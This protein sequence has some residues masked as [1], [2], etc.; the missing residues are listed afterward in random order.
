[1]SNTDLYERVRKVP[2]NAKKQISAGRLKGMTDINP[3]WRIKTLTEEFG[4]CGIGWKLEIVRSWLDNGSNNEVTANVEIRLYVKVNEQWSDA[5]P[6]I[7]GSKFVSKETGGMYTDDDAYK[8]AYTDALS[9]ACKALGIGADVYYEKDTTKYST[10]QQ[11]DSGKQGDAAGKHQLQGSTQQ[12]G[13][14]R[15]K[16]KFVQVNDLIKDTDISM[17]MVNEFISNN[18]GKSI[19]NNNLTDE[20]FKKL[21]FTLRKNL[22]IE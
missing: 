15:P 12:Q 10:P 7:G 2:D 8:K 13:G 4:V 3:M 1:M 20:Q 17:S 9:V 11:P 16:S 19:K 18:Y 22:G 14:E 21:M 6:G 5:I